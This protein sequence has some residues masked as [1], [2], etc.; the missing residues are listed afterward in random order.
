MPE[1]LD[2]NALFE[3]HAFEN[4][5]P[6]LDVIDTSGRSNISIQVREF[7]QFLG[8]YDD[9]GDRLD[10][11]VWGYMAG[12]LGR[13]PG[14]TIVAYRDQPVTIRWQNQLPVDGH[15]L[16]IDTSIDLADPVRRPLDDRFV[17]IVTHLHGGHNLSH[18]TARQSSGSRST[19]AARA[20]MARA[21]SAPTS[22]HRRCST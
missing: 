9:E 15:L 14:P 22:S 3:E 21:R 17:P 16:P 20:D 13:Y 8:L 1:L 12:G 11:T 10:T 5:L 4:S 19:E 6:I 2:A 7:D 18:S